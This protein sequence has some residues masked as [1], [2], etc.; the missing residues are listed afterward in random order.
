MT[1]SRFRRIAPH[2]ALA[3]LE[4]GA[5]RDDGNGAS[6]SGPWY[7]PWHQRDGNGGVPEDW[8]TRTFRFRTSGTTAAPAVWVCSGARLAADAAQLAALPG[9]R[10][11]EA[12][13]GFAPA[14]H[15]YGACA[16]VMLPMLLGLP[17]WFWPSPDFAP[18]PVRAERLLVVAIPWSFRILLRHLE[19]LKGFSS[20]TVL[21]SSAALPGDA[22]RLHTAMARMGIDC[23]LTEI[24]GSTETGAVAHRSGWSGQGPWTL[25]DDM[26]FVHRARPGE[27]V[28]L[29]VS[30]PRL[31][32]DQRGVEIP[33][34]E[35]DDLVE[36]LDERRFVFHGRR[37][38]L[39]KIN[40]ERLDLDRV[41][42]RLRAALPQTELVCLP[43]CDSLRGEN[44]DVVVA[45]RP[46]ISLEAVRAASAGLGLSPG[47]IRV[48]DRIT[49]SELGKPRSLQQR[50]A[51]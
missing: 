7:V 11:V 10:G 29:V 40:G 24:F 5:P 23:G 37:G 48:V 35:M 30:G 12:V 50:E 17:A 31:A 33:Y 16:G 45:D 49:Y 2:R 13:V 28:R 20:V 42:E 43:I 27:E 9:L 14:R 47:A 19:W 8:Q 1:V 41:E 22:A 32:R 3:E 51:R 21:H 39:V 18:P 34:W 36:I 38:R 44:F 26:E 6:L 15:T 46:G 4:I 25:F